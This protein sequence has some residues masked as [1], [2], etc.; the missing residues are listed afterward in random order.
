MIPAWQKEVPTGFTAIIDTPF[1]FVCVQAD[2]A[3]QYAIC[4]D[5]EGNGG[6][7]YAV[8]RGQYWPSNGQPVTLYSY[9]R[10]LCPECG[11]LGYGWKK[12]LKA[13]RIAKA[14]A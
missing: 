1:N 14:L 9:V 4:D 6:I 3:D 12:L 11:G 10:T 13:G 2:K 7:H 5:C 8:H